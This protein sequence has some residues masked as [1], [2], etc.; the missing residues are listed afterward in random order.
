MHARKLGLILL[1]ASIVLFTVIGILQLFRGDLLS[2]GMY[3]LG[4]LL[5]VAVLFYVRRAPSH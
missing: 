3:I 4:A 5:A 2:S 1:A